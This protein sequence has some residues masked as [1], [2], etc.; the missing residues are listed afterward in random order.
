[1]KTGDVSIF[2]LLMCR[3]LPPLPPN[4][5]IIL[6]GPVVENLWRLK[7]GNICLAKYS[8]Y[9]WRGRSQRSPSKRGGG[10]KWKKKPFGKR[11]VSQGGTELKMIGWDRGHSMTGMFS[12]S[13]CNHKGVCPF[14]IGGGDSHAHAAQRL[15]QKPPVVPV[16]FHQSDPAAGLGRVIGRKMQHPTNLT[17][18]DE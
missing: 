5:A 16:V 1:M 17:R 6:I 4:R 11:R 13:A 10:Q 7:M 15:A 2:P 14:L 18:K 3:G 9:R 12:A 8:G